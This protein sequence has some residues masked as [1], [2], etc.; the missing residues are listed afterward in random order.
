MYQVYIV[1]LSQR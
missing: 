1:T